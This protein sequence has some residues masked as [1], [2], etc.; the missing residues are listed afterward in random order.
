MPHFSDDA[1]TIDQP[2][3]V[4]MEHRVKPQVKAEISRAAALLGVDESTFVM[5]AAYERA[6][7][8]IRDHDRTEL[9][10]ADRALFLKALD[11]PAFAS[12]ALKKAAAL[13]QKRVHRGA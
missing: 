12:P 10:A 8:T 13:H 9:T 11:A 6:K 7:E 2:K 3:S 4:R 1:A 5:S